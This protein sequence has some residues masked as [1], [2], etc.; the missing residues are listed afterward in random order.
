MILYD[1]YFYVTTVNINIEPF[2]QVA[3]IYLM[4][5]IV[6]ARA[7]ALKVEKPFAYFTVTLGDIGKQ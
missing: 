1:G 6:G 7:V 5:N 4:E 3:D 2:Q